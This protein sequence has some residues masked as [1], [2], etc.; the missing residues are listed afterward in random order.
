MSNV[1][2]PLVFVAA[3]TLFLTV[4]AAAQ[5]VLLRGAT[6]GE[7][8]EVF[9]NGEKSA[10]GTVGPDGQVSLESTIPANEA[11]RQEM[12]ARVY[13]DVCGKAHRVQIVNRNMPVPPRESECERREISGIFWVRQRSTLVIDVAG[14]IP[15]LLLRQGSYDPNAILRIRRQ[16]PTG[17]VIFGGGGWGSLSNVRAA[18]CGTVTDCVGEDGGGAYTAGA[19]FWITKFL[20]AEATFLRPAKADYRGGGT[21]F[22]FTHALDA[23][24]FTV[25]GILAAPIGPVRLYGKGGGSY[26][27]AIAT[28]VQIQEDS[29]ITVDGEPVT[30]PGGTQTF[31][32]ETKG[33]GWL[34]GGGLEGWVTPRFALYT[35]AGLAKLKG[36]AVGAENIER[37][38]SVSYIVAGTR[39]RLF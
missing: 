11:G 25:A 9:V 24:A 38:D 33:W 10:S 5:T 37:S 23:E 18:G 32:L 26:H 12:D 36:P 6:P 2:R 4:P 17:L 15:T 27:R 13:V 29:V 30:I 21:G 3:F 8:V 28:T 39:L 34:F 1:W 14:A 19:A 31:A 16:S 20:A 35:E 7:P 22:D